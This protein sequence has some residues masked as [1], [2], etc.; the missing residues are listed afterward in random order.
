[1]NKKQIIL[2]FIIGIVIMCL[3]CVHFVLGNTFQSLIE[4]VVGYIFISSAINNWPK[5]DW[6]LV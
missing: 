3:G 6:V 1:M 2:T 5:G 4:I